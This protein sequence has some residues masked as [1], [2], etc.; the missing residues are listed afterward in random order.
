ML[1]PNRCN[2]NQ[3]EYTSHNG[4]TTVPMP[5]LSLMEMNTAQTP[6]ETFL[7]FLV[8]DEASCL[9]GAPTAFISIRQGS[10]NPVGGARIAVIASVANSMLNM[11]LQA[12]L[13][14]C[15]NRTQY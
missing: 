7:Y 3:M 14:G 9:S 10:L 4:S 11:N 15:S 6:H 2:T 1:N 12:M 5:V 13:L 8:I